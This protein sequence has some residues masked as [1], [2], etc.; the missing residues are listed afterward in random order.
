M[1]PNDQFM[2]CFEYLL[3]SNSLFPGFSFDDSVS[4]QITKLAYN[5]FVKAEMVT[6]ARGSR[7]KCGIIIRGRF[8]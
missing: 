8:N 4:R 6:A 7:C 5:S 1:T 2:V 3:F